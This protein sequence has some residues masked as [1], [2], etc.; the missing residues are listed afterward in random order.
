MS[1]HVEKTNMSNKFETLQK[2]RHKSDNDW[3]T[4]T[5]STKRKQKMEHVEKCNKQSSHVENERKYAETTQ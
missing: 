1:K 5:K 3:K 4:Q 2:S